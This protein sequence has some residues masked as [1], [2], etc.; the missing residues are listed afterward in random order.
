MANPSL[1]Q[2]NGVGTS[3]NS[4]A[5]IAASLT[6]PS[7]AGTFL[8]LAVACTGSSP[9]IS[10]PT[11]W[12]LVIGASNASIAVAL[13]EFPKNPGAISSVTVTLNNATNGGA[14][15]SM[16]E[17][18]PVFGVPTVEVQTAFTQNAQF[19]FSGA[20][21]QVQQ[22]EEISL[23]IVAFQASV[24]AT[25]FRTGGDYSGNTA[26]VSSTVA[27]TNVTIVNEFAI[28][29]SSTT[30]TQV[31]GNTNV[32]IDLSGTAQTGII[33]VRFAGIGSA[34][35]RGAGSSVFESQA[36]N[37]A[38][39]LQVPQPQQSGNFFSGSIGIG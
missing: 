17:F 4:P 5:T 9:T 28:N 22:L 29:A 18:N 10:T 14:V 25:N 37:P 35:G 39:S 2:S 27:T 26:G 16:F 7:T 19:A 33:L 24:T 38:G 1:L 13:F 3:V 11:N 31:G 15:A 12:T 34:I 8:L 23:F 30:P 21:A 6:S 20:V 32:G 36:G